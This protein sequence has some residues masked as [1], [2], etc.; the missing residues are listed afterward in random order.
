MRRL[1]LLS[2]L[3]LPAG[4]PAADAAKR[5]AQTVPPRASNPLLPKRDPVTGQRCARATVHHAAPLV[6]PRSNKLGEL[7]PA[8]LAL[9]VYREVGGCQTPVI[10]RYGIGAGGSGDGMPA[11]PVPLRSKRR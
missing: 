10:V 5:S 3:L 6:A 11:R 8:N 9:A 7:P 2:A 4:A 1:V